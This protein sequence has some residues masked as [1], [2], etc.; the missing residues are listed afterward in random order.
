MQFI[1]HFYQT[2]V[3]TQIFNT[4]K[5]IATFKSIN[6]S[7]VELSEIT[8]EKSIEHAV[9]PGGWQQVHFNGSRFILHHPLLLQFY[10]FCQY[11]E[12]K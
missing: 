9:D 11:H 8:Q 2:L 6:N 12:M 7:Y 10:E 3:L 1:A 4:Y 5:E